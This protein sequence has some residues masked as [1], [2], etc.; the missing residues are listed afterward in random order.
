MTNK[1]IRL[2]AENIKRLSAVTIDP[3]GNIVVIGG[4]NGQGK[5]SVLDSIQYAL[6]G[7][8]TDPMPVRK[9]E[10]KAKVVVDLGD[11]VVRRS[12]TAAGGTALVIKNADG[13]EQKS[14]QA[15]LDGLTGKLAFDPLEF[16][17]QKP[18]AQ[19]ETLR[20]LVG[21]DFTVLNQ[22]HEGAY[23]ERT[24]VNREAKALLAQVQGM[25]KHE[26]V[27]D[28]EIDTWSILGEQD[29]AIATNKA[30][31]GFRAKVKGS[32]IRLVGFQN[33]MESLE[34]G[35][36]DTKNQI[37]R[38]QKQL[39]DQLANLKTSAE[40]LSKDETEHK[41]L[42]KQASELIDIDLS[43]FTALLSQADQTN[44]KIRANAQRSQVVARYKA[45]TAKA[46]A[47]TAKL[48]GIEAE[49]RK[50]INSAKW[51]IE[52]LSFDT[53][54]GVTLNGIPFNQASSAEQLRVSVAIGLAL[55]PKLR[56]LLIRDGSL[57]DSDSLAILADMAAKADA[58]VW[59][60]RVGV[61]AETSVVIEDGTVKTEEEAK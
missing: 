38:L 58:Q 12:F 27:P 2:E 8:T 34:R 10:D 19:A 16:S 61:G 48:D 50:R 15:I 49:K 46:E 21:L 47:L 29:K 13:V 4:R 7:A 11:I 14:P 57:L 25:P 1:I 22:Q 28:A 35:V 44:R 5:S 55:N 36:L 52:G 31:D 20:A 6:G 24:N 60:E 37:T 32:E 43:T 3:K 9:G 39:A 53:A 40:K 45:A 56:V 17:R 23:Q 42:E 54:G 41:A 33:A 30:N 26:G 18:Q 59:V 51:P